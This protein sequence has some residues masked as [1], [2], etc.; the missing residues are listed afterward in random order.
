MDP[1]GRPGRQDIERGMIC[2]LTRRENQEVW[3]ALAQIEPTHTRIQ[4]FDTV[5]WIHFRQVQPVVRTSR[6]SRS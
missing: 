3:P 2:D 5:W 4:V 6:A 1:S